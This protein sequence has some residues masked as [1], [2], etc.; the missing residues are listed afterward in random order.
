MVDEGAEALVGGADGGVPA[1]LE[2]DQRAVVGCRSPLPEVPGRC[3]PLVALGDVADDAEQIAGPGAGGQRRSIALA[4]EGGDPGEDGIV[5]V[6]GDG[7]LDVAGGVVEAQAHEDLVEQRPDDGVE[8]GLARLEAEFLASVTFLQLRLRGGDLFLG[9]ALALVELDT[10]P[11]VPV[12]ARPVV[13]GA[14]VDGQDHGEDRAGEIL[15]GVAADDEGRGG[16]L[17]EAEGAFHRGIGLWSA[18]R[19]P[20]VE[21]VAAE[22][23]SDLWSVVGGAVVRVE[24]ER[25]CAGGGDAVLEGLDDGLGILFGT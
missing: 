8:T 14:A 1:L 11:A 7:V 18:E 23:L 4:D 3:E 13:G 16:L 24:G 19:G 2:S 12:I 15:V 22:G 25:F 5:G 10:A 17:E 6:A 9:R 21:G 20:D